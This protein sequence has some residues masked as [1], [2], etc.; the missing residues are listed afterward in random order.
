MAPHNATKEL[1][2]VMWCEYEN[3]MMNEYDDS[4]VTI[5]GQL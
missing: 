3:N 2:D 1:C 4:K 5:N